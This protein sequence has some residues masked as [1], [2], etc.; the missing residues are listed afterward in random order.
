MTRTIRASLV[1]FA[2]L[3]ALSACTRDE[4]VA[5]K[6]VEEAKSGPTNR[7]DI[8]VAVRRNLGITFAKV[9]PR[10]VASTLR[11]PGRFEFTP[12]AR[13]ECRA[14]VGGTVEYAVA[15][16]A[17]VDAG[18]LLCTLDSPAW[19]DL[20]QEIAATEAKVASMGPLRSAHRVHE[21]SLAE[22]VKLWETRL[23]QLEEIRAA[24]GA[25]ATQ[26]TD[27]R[28][29]LIATRA[30]L[31]DVMEKDAT[32][33]S[34]QREAEARLRALRA[35]QEAIARS[36]GSAGAEAAV[37]A[38]GRLDIRA[39]VAG[40]VESL[41]ATQGGLVEEGGALVTLVDPARLRFH[42]RGLQS[43]LGRLRDGLAARVVPPQGGSLDTAKPMDAT[44]AIGL[45]GDARDRTID[46]F[47]VP[48]A[49]EPWARDG[50]TAYLEVTLAGGREELAIPL[51]AVIRD[52]GTPMIFRRDPANADKVIRM[53]ADLGVSDGRWVVIQSGVKE[54][55]EIVVGG[56]YQLM[57]AT[58][59]RMP[60]GGH[61]HSDGTWHEEDH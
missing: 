19:R 17:R 9:E 3:G 31:A 40:T 30:E 37:R 7:V 28:A 8:P 14:P 6:P 15:Q 16:F 11:V 52:A 44:L 48:P 54:G 18:A 36:A 1:L 51:A 60:K 38:D 22:K 32:L 46:L 13:R 42:A 4:P 56:N 34:D 59:G 20:A 41:A 35:R 26:V 25:N 53:E 49:I 50:V 21:A 5:A 47:A 61:F 24:G 57:L 58:A 2:A 29:T 23:A 39:R 45:T 43:D 10:A 55:D 12:D 27:A 33:E